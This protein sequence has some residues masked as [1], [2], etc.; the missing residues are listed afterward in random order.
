MR[1]DWNEDGPGDKFVK[2]GAA[3]NR[4]RQP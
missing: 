2:V 3:K 1:L 4:N